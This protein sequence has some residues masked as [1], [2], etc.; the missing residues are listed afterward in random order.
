MYEN[1]TTSVRRE[2]DRLKKE[3][4]QRTSQLASLK[5]D[6]SRHQKVYGL[7]R[8]ADRTETEKTA[9]KGKKNCSG[10]LG[11]GAARAS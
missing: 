3:I 11:F 5:D 4:G 8:G 10:E 2:I 7:L 6:L 9:E 1:L